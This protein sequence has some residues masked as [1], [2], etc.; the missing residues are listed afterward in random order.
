MSVAIV[1]PSQNRKGKEAAYILS[2]VLDAD[3][4]KITLFNIQPEK[5]RKVL[6]SFSRR[7]ISFT[8]RINTLSTCPIDIDKYKYIILL[9]YH[10]GKHLSTECLSF[11]NSFYQLFIHSPSQL[12]LLYLGNYSSHAIN[13]INRIH[14]LF[15]RN[16]LSQSFLFFTFQ[17]SF[18]FLLSSFF[19]SSLLVKVYIY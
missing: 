7:T 19:C 11:L 16:N 8:K 13:D 5:K 10:E 2:S 4:F 15:E 9:C 1:Y 18:V 12:L 14:S 17:L 3:S 6:S